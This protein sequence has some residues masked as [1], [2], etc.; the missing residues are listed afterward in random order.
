MALSGLSLENE[1]VKARA[2]E[3]VRGLSEF[4]NKLGQIEGKISA[5][6]RKIVDSESRARDGLGKTIS[7]VRQEL[8]GLH[9]QIQA[10]Q[11][12]YEREKVKLGNGPDEEARAKVLKELVT[13][14]MERLQLIS[15]IVSSL[16]T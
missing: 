9:A 1:R 6:S 13:S 14:W 4:S 10:N 12:Q 7:S 5:E 11:R 8:E 2:D 16:P 3:S 15:V